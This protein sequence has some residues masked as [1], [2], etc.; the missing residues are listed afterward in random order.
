MQ[1]TSMK[2]PSNQRD[3]GNINIRISGERSTSSIM[4][5]RT[6]FKHTNTM[7]QVLSHPATR[8]NDSFEFSLKNESKNISDFHLQDYML[9]PLFGSTPE[10]TETNPRNPKNSIHFFLFTPF[11]TKSTGNIVS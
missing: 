4:L 5:F 3:D 2:N 7:I 8:S 11:S 10:T 6:C 9:S 1:N